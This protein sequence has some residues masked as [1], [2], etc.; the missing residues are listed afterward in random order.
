VAESGVG[1]S[2]VVSWTQWAL[3]GTSDVPEQTYG[4]SPVDSSLTGSDVTGRYRPPAA[5]LRPQSP[6]APRKP[7]RDIPIVTY[8]VAATPT[9]TVRPATVT[10]VETTPTPV[11][12]PSVFARTQECL[13]FYGPGARV[14]ITV[15]TVR[16]TA[17]AGD[18]AVMTWWHNGDQS[19]IAYWVGIRPDFGGRLQRG[20]IRWVH[21]TPPTDCHDVV[22]SIPGLTRGQPYTLLLDLESRTPETLSGMSRRTLNEVPWSSCPDVGTSNACV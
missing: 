18:T 5:P 15:R 12:T 7:I 4:S 13:P 19:G 1:P 10:L 17:T 8:G 6:L 11:V 16:G 2:T 22:F 20:R 21:L 3:G 14:P 9:P